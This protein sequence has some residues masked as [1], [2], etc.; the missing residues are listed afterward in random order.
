MHTPFEARQ[1]YP[2][3]TIAIGDFL[4]SPK[5][6]ATEC[7]N[8]RSMVTVSSGHGLGLLRKN[9]SMNRLHVC[10]VAARLVALTL[11]WLL[12]DDHGPALS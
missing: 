12:I 4:V 11:G 9:Y 6:Q 8:Y 1:P 3:S 2:P 7:G 5:P 10:P